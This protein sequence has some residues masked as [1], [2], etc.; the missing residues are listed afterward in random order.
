MPVPVLL[1]STCINEDI[2]GLEV[3]VQDGGLTLLQRLH[4]PRYSQRHPHLV[5]QAAPWRAPVQHHIARRTLAI[6]HVHAS[7]LSLA[8]K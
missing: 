7:N 8:S 4:A 5:C 2:G 3:A 1:P 6:V